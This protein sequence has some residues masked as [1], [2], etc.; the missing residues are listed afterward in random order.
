LQL[1]SIVPTLPKRLQ[2]VD[3]RFPWQSVEEC[4]SVMSGL[5]ATFVE[6]IPSPGSLKF[7]V[8][9]DGDDSS[10]PSAFKIRHSGKPSGPIVCELQ[11]NGDGVS[12]FRLSSLRP[13]W[14]F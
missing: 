13:D 5:V 7:V 10:K 11:G 4:K 2:A 8:I 9:G 12:E 1:D 3:L 14:I 6:K